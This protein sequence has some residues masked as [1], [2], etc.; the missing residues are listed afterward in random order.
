MRGV[1][2]CRGSAAGPPVVGAGNRIFLYPATSLILFLPA[3]VWFYWPAADG[4]DVSGYPIGRDFINIWAGPQLAF[5]GQLSTLF[6]PETYHAAIGA[7]F[8]HALPFHNWSYP[9]F[10]LAA[11]WPLSELPYFPALAVWTLA[12][13]AA[14]A[15]VVLSQL[16]SPSRPCALLGLIAAPAVLLNLVAGQN[17]FASAALLLGGILWLDRRPM[18]AG[19]LFGLL[20]FKPQLGLVLP[21]ALLALGAWRAIAAATSTVC[22]LVTASVALFG[23]EAWQEYLHVTAVYQLLLLEQF[24]GFYT[25]M[26][27]SVFAGARTFGF[28]Y[29]A[30]MSI[31]GAVALSVMAG[32][33]LAV[34]R[35]GD[36]CRRALVLASAAPLLTPYALNYDLTAIAGAVIWMLW[37][38]LPWRADWSPVCLLAWIMPLLVMVLNPLG[39]GI[40]PLALAAL[41]WMSVREAS[42]GANSTASGALQ[43]QTGLALPLRRSSA[44]SWRARAA[45]AGRR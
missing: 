36:P 21:F 15:G 4:L 41:F 24:Q 16:A 9:L 2:A 44:T 25:A 39:L 11:F 1:E 42:E 31:Q 8:G 40:A 6:D 20:A 28:S 17:G 7:L 38:R 19:V 45:A 23:L 30:A 29:P 10:A 18:M 14:Y 22:V 34:R 32:A 12:T 43:P 27:P 13:F 35:T 5:H 3:F 37:G 33:C 26:M